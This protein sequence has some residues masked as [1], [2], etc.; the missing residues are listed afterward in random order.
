MG[1]QGRGPRRQSQGTAGGEVVR[2]TPSAVPGRKWRVLVEFQSAFRKAPAEAVVATEL[3]QV[4][5]LVIPV[6]LP[7]DN[8]AAAAVGP[9]NRATRKELGLHGLLGATFGSG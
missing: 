1:G 9:E 8:D 2:L 7:L 5:P 4:E 3:H 6:F